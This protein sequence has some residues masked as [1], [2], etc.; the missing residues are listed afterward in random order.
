MCS[1]FL[2]EPL[3]INP[4]AMAYQVHFQGT[5]LLVRVLLGENDECFTGSTYL[6]ISDHESSN[7]LALE[8]ININ[9]FLVHVVQD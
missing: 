7:C 6:N 9:L 3:F 1:V 5:N 8:L 4:V 2:S